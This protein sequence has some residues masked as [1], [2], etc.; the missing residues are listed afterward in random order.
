VLS[1]PSSKFDS[2]HSVGRN[3]HAHCLEPIADFDAIDRSLAGEDEVAEDMMSVSDM[4][5]GLFKVLYWA[6]N[7]YADTPQARLAAVAS[8]IEALLWLLQ[9]TECRF[10]SLTDIAQ[11]AGI[12]KASV[13]KALVN[14]RD[15]VG[16]DFLRVSAT[17]PATFTDGRRKLR[18]RRAC[19]RL[20]SARRKS[21]MMPLQ[22]RSLLSQL[23]STS[24]FERRV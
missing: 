5:S 14:F 22:I 7:A 9:P 6:T 10:E 18:S 1:Q 17:T 4:S 21:N 12:T 19:I 8:R 16:Y 23:S 3:H 15:E 20:A 24:S 2:V 13:S 11:A